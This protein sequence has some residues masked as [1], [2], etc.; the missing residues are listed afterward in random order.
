MSKLSY[1][2][3]KKVAKPKFMQ[4]TEGKHIVRFTR[5][6]EVGS[7][8]NYDGSLKTD[9]PEWD[10]ET[11]QLAVTMV[12]AEDG[13]S[14][15]ITHRFNGCGFLK[16]ED[17]SEKQLKTG[18]Y[19]DIQGYA[20]YEHKEGDQTF[21]MREESSENIEA[22][23][24]I[25]DQFSAAM[26]FEEDSDFYE[27]LESAIAEQKTV[28]ITVVSKVWDGKDQLKVERFKSASKVKDTQFEE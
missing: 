15:G 13:K 7:F 20:C 22:C 10:N 12:A 18:K 17:L 19:V 6:E 16:Y 21:T 2:K 1:F 28:E 27:S 11:P 3:S 9:L 8:H 4:L 26:G 23:D 14:G 25:L 24:N 5:V